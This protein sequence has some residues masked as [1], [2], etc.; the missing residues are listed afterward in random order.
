M[1]GNIG[2]NISTALGRPSLKR[3]SPIAYYDG[4]MDCIRVELRDCS[5]TEERINEHVTFL[6][7]NYPGPQRSAVAGI[8]IKGIKHFFASAGLPMDGILYVTTILDKLVKHYPI[9]AEQQI[10][11][12][13]NELDLTVDMSEPDAVVPA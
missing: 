7:D 6:Q 12:L 13:V 8:M 5:F 1:V 11:K 9:L 2:E 4:H 10:L 3:F